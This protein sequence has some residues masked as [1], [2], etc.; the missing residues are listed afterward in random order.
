M[1]DTGH[2]P[3]LQRL[4]C[5][6]P[7][8]AAACPPG[9]GQGSRQP[10]RECEPTPLPAAAAAGRSPRADSATCPLSLAPPTPVCPPR[11][12]RCPSCPPHA[13][14][15]LS[16]HIQ[17]TNGAQGSHVAAWSAGSPRVLQEFPP[18]PRLGVRGGGPAPSPAPSTCRGLRTRRPQAGAALTGGPA[19]GHPLFSTRPGLGKGI[20]PPS[21][22]V[23]GNP[24]K[25][26]EQGP[27][28]P[29]GQGCPKCRGHGAQARDVE[30][31][32]QG[33]SW[34]D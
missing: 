11:M 23:S 6:P 13:P 1:G 31:T 5:Q 22:L 4:N 34:R 25:R 29:N 16:H 8:A 14:T 27:G 15:L 28:L 32:V 2:S 21:L 30:R 24:S 12:A 10:A 18:S 20:L 3:A 7:L 17:G 19:P 33:R 26:Q 9:P